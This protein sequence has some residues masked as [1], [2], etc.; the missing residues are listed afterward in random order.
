MHKS[1]LMSVMLD[2]PSDSAEDGVEFW[3]K[4]LGAETDRGDSDSPYTQ[5]KGDHLPLR[6][7]VQEVQSPPRI[8]IDIE[9]D[10]L[11]AEVSRLESLGARRVEKKD[12]WWIMESPSGHVFCVVSVQTSDF[13]E[14]AVTWG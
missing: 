9:T 12:W 10:D 14:R 7:E 5:L 1:R 2:T 6:M 13:P 8:H 3:S 11:E 4:A